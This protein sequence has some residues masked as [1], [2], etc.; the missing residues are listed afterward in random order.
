MIK[1]DPTLP[2]HESKL[3]NAVLALVR[4]PASVPTGANA[5]SEDVKPNSTAPLDVSA[6]K[7]EDNMVVQGETVE[8]EVGE[9]LAKSEIAG[10]VV[11]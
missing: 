4:V 2:A 1:V 11:M 6:V 10:F 5:G 3:L 9:E 7:S 8:G